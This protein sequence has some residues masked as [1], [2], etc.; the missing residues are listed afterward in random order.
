MVV[1]I[2]SEVLG[3]FV[4]QGYH[5]FFRG[6]LFLGGMLVW[7]MKAPNVTYRFE[8]L[9]RIREEKLEMK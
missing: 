7:R 6:L 3:D 9:P 2:L 4:K 8:T 1:C 5:C